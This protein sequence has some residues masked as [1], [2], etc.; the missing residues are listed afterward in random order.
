MGTIL[1]DITCPWCGR[2]NARGFAIDST[3]YP[4]CAEPVD[5][6]CLDKLINGIT[7]NGIRA[8]A[9]HKIMTRQSGFQAVTD[10]RP[11][12]CL[13]VCDLIYGME[14]EL[15]ISD[16]YEEGLMD[17]MLAWANRFLEEDRFLEEAESGDE[18]R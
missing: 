11:S 13:E 2:R 3:E 16:N 10:A 14:T 8:A 7:C 15:Y 6:S 17:R 1:E 12:F 9:L 18:E 4:I 5:H